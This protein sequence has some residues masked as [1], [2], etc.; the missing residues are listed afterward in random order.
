MQ[1]ISRTILTLAIAH[2]L[3]FSMALSSHAA[4]IITAVETGGDVV[5]TAAGG[6]S[7]DLTGLSKVSFANR[8]SFIEPVTGSFATGAS[9]GVDQYNGA[10]TGPAQFGAG[11]FSA[12]TTGV[13]PYSGIFGDGAPILFIIEGYV[14]GSPLDESTSVYA[15]QTFATLGITT[16]TYVWNLPNDTMTLNIV[17]TIPIPAAA[18]LFGSALGLLGWMR[19]KAV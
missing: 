1:P 6:G 8:L 14:S 16:G 2:I 15:G 7:L 9:S 3:S 12:R 10:I 4:S 17:N 19:R 5:F 13:G 18:W 11:T